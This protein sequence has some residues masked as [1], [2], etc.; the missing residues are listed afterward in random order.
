[1]LAVLEMSENVS[2]LFHSCI[3]SVFDVS[4]ILEFS[5]FT[6]KLISASNLS[7]FALKLCMLID[8]GLNPLHLGSWLEFA[9][10]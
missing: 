4:H 3:I 5:L 9:F 6:S 7:F 2:L 8:R 10:G 1:M